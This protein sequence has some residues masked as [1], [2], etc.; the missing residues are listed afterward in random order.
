MVR[1]TIELIPFGFLKPKH[2]GTIDIV[3]DGSGYSD[4]GNYKAILYNAGKRKYKECEIKNFP[5]KKLLAFDLLYR[6]LKSV[7]GERNE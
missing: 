4:L 7:V 2:L 5:R 3:N 6:V 1:I